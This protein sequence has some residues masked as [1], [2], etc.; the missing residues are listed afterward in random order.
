MARMGHCLLNIVSRPHIHDD[1]LRIHQRAGDVERGRQ[2]HEEGLPCRVLND[3]PFLSL[4]PHVSNGRGGA[5]VPSIL[6]ETPSLMEVKHSRNLFCAARSFWKEV[7]RCSSSS[8]RRFLTEASCWAERVARSTV[9]WVS[10]DED[11]G[12]REGGGRRRKGRGGTCLGLGFCHCS[13]RGWVW[14]LGLGELGG[15]ILS[16]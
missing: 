16:V 13:G 1:V 4:V 11:E 5:C 10:R 15:S 7:V 8:S 12:E 2:R 9:W 6:R 3:C 14:R